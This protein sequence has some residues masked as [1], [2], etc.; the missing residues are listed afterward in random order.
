ML[1]TGQIGSSDDDDTA[2]AK[3]A[4]AAELGGAAATGTTALEGSDAAGGCDR[5]HTVAPPP[6]IMR[7]T[8]NAATKPMSNVRLRAAG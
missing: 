3:G 7:P 4:T 2:G 1:D 8:T 6:T 5:T